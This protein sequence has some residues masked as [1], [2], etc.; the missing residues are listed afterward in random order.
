MAEL[1]EH[2]KMDYQK[3]LART[4]SIIRGNKFRITVLSEILVRLEYSE[5]GSFEDRPTELVMNRNFPKV[6]FEKKEDS[7]YLT[8]KN[9]YFTLTYHKEMPFLGSKVSP[10]QNLRIELN[11]TDKYWYFNHPEV[12]NFRG[13][14]FS[15]DGADGKARYGKGL[16]STDGFVSL[17]DSKTLIFNE[18]GSLG[19][20]NDKRIDTYVFMYRRDFGACL[21]DYF[22]LTGYP[23]LIPRYSLGVWWNRNTTYSSKDI[24]RL[25]FNFNKYRIPLSIIML[26]DKW[27]RD[28]GKITSGLSFNEKLFKRPKR[29]AEFLH[30]K[31]IRL[32]VKVDPMQGISPTEDYY[33]PFKNASGLEGEGVLPFNVFNKNVLSAYF[34]Y[35]IHP[36]M[37]YGVDFF[38]IDYD[39]INDKTSLRAL[40]H[41]HF[42]DF[43]Q[44]T[45]RRGITFARNAL[46]A[47]H[48]YPIHYTGETIVSWNN[49]K[50][51]PT[52]NSTASNIGISWISND[53]GGYTGGIEDGELYT[54]FVQFGCFSP[55]FRLSADEGRYYKRE[56]WK[57][58]ITTQS[59]CAQY[60]RLRH[61]LIPYIYSEAYRYSRT[62]LP[63]VQPLY[64]RYPE[65]YD[66]P[67]YKAE[68][69]FGSG[70]FVAPITTK[71]DELMDRTVLKLFLPEGTWYDFTTGKRYAG[72]RRYTSFYKQE[73]YPVFA[74]SGTIIPLA[75]LD[76]N[77][78]ND[79]NPPKNM[80]IQIF[81]GASNTY[82]LYEDDGISSLYEQ[83]F[84]I[85]TNI[86][87]TYQ[88][89]NFTVIIRPVAGKSGIIPPHRA[90]RIRFRNTREP[91]DVIIHVGNEKVKGAQMY[92]DDNDFVVELPP[93]ST[94]K[95]ITVN[96]KGKDIEI[97]ALRL[98]N[99]DIESILNDLPIQTKIKNVIG[100]IIFDD[101]EI[102]QKRIQIRKLKKLGVNSKYINL[103]LK[104]LEYIAEV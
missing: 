100:E 92:V 57:W 84:Y 79:T 13:T 9:S 86:D 59:V 44:I 61:S 7:K 66:E 47:A 51:L 49:L 74:R 98:V 36:L 17:D 56:P 64:Y 52:Y 60:M 97:D 85:M 63:L 68:Y 42:N 65:I 16:Y 101:T 14:S 5:T 89:N 91:D 54:R 40:T 73:D 69:F 6:K 104:L 67:L 77:H 70:L 71:R 76:E 83:D 27:H 62:G 41:Y 39:N 28:N 25:V 87:Y 19:K 38:W 81:P 45:N 50:L 90:Y 58:D 1:Q 102:K 31:D 11:N 23:P 18:D 2:F 33:L 48:R 80:E 53:I 94:L 88:Q 78:L 32:A 10:D 93:L 26:G 99:D 82:E 46:I 4:D 96:C 29:M 37:N 72:G 43:K 75:I 12:R 21:R 20:R 30:G 35:L 34:D 55:I 3:I 95:Q 103:F 15:L 22:T 24:E 8:I